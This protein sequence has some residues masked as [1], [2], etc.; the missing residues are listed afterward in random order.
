MSTVC[1]EKLA[2]AFV[3][4]GD[5]LVEVPT[6]DRCLERALVPKRLAVGGAH[7]HEHHRAG[8]QTLGVA[9][10]SRIARAVAHVL[11]VRLVVAHL[12]VVNF[13]HAR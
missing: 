5:I 10:F 7:G 9:L 3:S 8:D 13:A 1:V 11:Q 6:L 4:D 12:L 2:L